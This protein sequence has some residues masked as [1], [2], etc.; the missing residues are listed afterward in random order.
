MMEKAKRNYFIGI[1]GT[2]GTYSLD[3]ALI[4][5][6]DVNSSYNIVKGNR[7]QSG[8]VGV[9]FVGS[10]A[11]QLSGIEIKNNVIVDFGSELK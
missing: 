2:A 8:S 4:R 5:D 9:S 1:Q 6:A 10:T 11:T 3:K 7:I